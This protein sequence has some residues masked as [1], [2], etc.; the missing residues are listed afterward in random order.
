LLSINDFAITAFCRNQ[1]AFSPLNMSPLSHS[2]LRRTSSW[3]LI[4]LITLTQAQSLLPANESDRLREGV[5]NV[6]LGVM[7]DRMIILAQLISLVD[8]GLRNIPVSVENQS[9]Y[10]ACDGV[11][12]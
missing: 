4:V 2:F 9:E 12:D 5:P 11:G 10:L 8:G 1:L 3:L 6:A 7:K